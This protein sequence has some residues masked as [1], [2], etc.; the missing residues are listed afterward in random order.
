MIASGFRLESSFFANFLH[1]IKTRNIV[2][3]LGGNGVGKTMFI[4]K[5]A[6]SL[7]GAQV[8]TQYKKVL[9]TNQMQDAREFLGVYDLINNNYIDPH[10][11]SA[12]I[13]RAY[14]DPDNPYILHL[15]EMNMENIEN[16]FPQFIQADD[17]AHR[18]ESDFI[19]I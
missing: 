9:I 14:H 15:D 7:L 2:C 10:G 17:L 18:G 8:N 4:E 11:V 19:K 12:L 1:T 5:L 16:Y 6:A 13:G 3:L